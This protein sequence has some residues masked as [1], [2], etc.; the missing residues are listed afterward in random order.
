MR[1]IEDFERSVC[2]RKQQHSFL[3]DFLKIFV[4]RNEQI[5]RPSSS[6]QTKYISNA[7]FRKLLFS[8][9]TAS[10]KDGLVA[11]FS[12][13]WDQKSIDFHTECVLICCLAI[14][15]IIVHVAQVARTNFPSHS[16]IDRVGRFE[17][18][19]SPCRLSLVE[20]LSLRSCW[21][22]DDEVCSCHAPTE[23]PDTL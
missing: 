22:L 7:D 10:R 1:K 15:H 8:K 21:F 12:S 20:Q 18:W 6:S 19:L 23:D 16:T 14:G 9:L 13:E 17:P 5:A 3:C 11:D 4:I 2:T